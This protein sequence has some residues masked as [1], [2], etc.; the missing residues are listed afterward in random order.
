MPDSTEK[1]SRREI[2]VNSISVTGDPGVVKSDATLMEL[3]NAYERTINAVDNQ[4][5]IVMVSS[6]SFLRTPRVTWFLRLLVID[7]ADRT[8]DGVCRR[9][10]AR[11]ADKT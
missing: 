9:Y 2:G 11:A 4:G 6:R 10:A 3:L 8:L 5:P 1:T 7:H